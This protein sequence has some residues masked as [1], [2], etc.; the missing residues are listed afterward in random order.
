MRRIVEGTPVFDL[1]HPI[2]IIGDAS[3]SVTICAEPYKLEFG[4][5]IMHRKIY[6]VVIVDEDGLAIKHV[7]SYKR[8]DNA[9][10]CAHRI[11]RE[12]ETKER[13]L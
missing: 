9:H 6:H 13:G 8:F 2:S 5:Q 4:D 1:F 10:K 11:F 7:R 12:L 3:H